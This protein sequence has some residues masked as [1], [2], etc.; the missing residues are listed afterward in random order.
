MHIVANNSA[1]Q[2]VTAGLWTYLASH[3]RLAF[4]MIT[5]AKL[6]MTPINFRALGPAG[7]TVSRIAYVRGHFLNLKPIHEQQ[8]LQYQSAQGSGATSTGNVPS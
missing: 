4:M 8:V 7:Q 2:H 3:R 5:L 1:I 6:V